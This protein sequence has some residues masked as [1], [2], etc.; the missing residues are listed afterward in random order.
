MHC[1]G[2]SIERRD[3]MGVL[4]AACVLLEPMRM[5]CSVWGAAL[6]QPMRVARSVRAAG[7]VCPPVGVGRAA[8]RIGAGV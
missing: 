8:R 5:A 6:R 2:E 1:I 7:A 3:I 4:R